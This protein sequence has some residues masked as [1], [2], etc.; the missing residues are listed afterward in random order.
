M[1]GPVVANIVMHSAY[2][3][4]FFCSIFFIALIVF[5]IKGSFIQFKTKNT[6]R[7]MCEHSANTERIFEYRN[8]SI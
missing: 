3:S 2:S 6:M 4:P 8:T 7:V 5:C 1:S